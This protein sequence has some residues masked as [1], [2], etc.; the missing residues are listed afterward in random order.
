MTVPDL[1]IVILS[2]NTQDLTLACLRS[3]QRDR[4][5]LT[6]EIIVVDNGSSDG[7][8][9]AIAAIPGVELLRNAENRGYSG[10]NNQGARRATGRWVCLLNSDTEVRPGALD[11]LVEFLST[12]P[13][14]GAVAPK[15]V[16]PDGSV[17][18]ACMRFPGLVTALCFDSTFG[19][20]PPGSWIQRRYF[21][22][23]F[24]H[25]TS[26]D[27]PQ[28]P[29]ACFLMDREEYLSM[30]GLDEELFL[31]FN[32]VDLCRRL[33]KRGRRIHYLA[34]AEVV[35]HRGASTKKYPHFVVTW[36]KNRIAY[37]R[38]NYGPWTV[39][40][41]HM[42]LRLRAFEESVKAKKK[43]DNPQHVRDERA[44]I[45]GIVKEIIGS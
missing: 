36:F 6:R 20:F 25:L 41:L 22:R 19:R 34:E 38:K 15:L 42:I 8:A 43:H 30:G 28:P 24:D 18:R 44:H 12:H 7:S 35:H 13:R 2:W 1:S 32:D 33:W 31:F 11:L 27:V 5:S 29:G 37:Y 10:G 14:H 45:R 23:D 40:Y 21:M 16:D 26:R 9:D 39:P 17:Q 3:L 4:T